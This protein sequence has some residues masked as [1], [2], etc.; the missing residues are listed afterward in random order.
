MGRFGSFIHE[1]LIDSDLFGSCKR[2]NRSASPSFGTF[3]KCMGGTHVKNL[4]PK[5]VRST[6]LVSIC[7]RVREVGQGVTKKSGFES[8]GKQTFELFAP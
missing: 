5:F 2:G 3:I 7:T 1:K 8:G 6:F 4:C